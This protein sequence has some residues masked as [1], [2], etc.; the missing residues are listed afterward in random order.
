MRIR[1][2]RKLPEV[3]P[4]V[5]PGGI[6]GVAPVSV[7][8][9]GLQRRLQQLA[10]GREGVPLRMELTPEAQRLLQRRVGVDAVQS[11][12]LVEALRGAAEQGAAEEA[13]QAARE[14]GFARRLLDGVQSY[15]QRLWGQRPRSLGA[16]AAVPNSPEAGGLGQRLDP[17]GLPEY[18]LRNA[19]ANNLV[20][21]QELRAQ[22]PVVVPREAV[23][24]AFSAVG[25]AV[26][27]GGGGGFV[28]GLLELSG[29]RILKGRL[30]DLQEGVYKT[31]RIFTYLWEKKG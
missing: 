2:R 19:V 10:E 27:G 25:P 4:E 30:D 23:A 18:W 1:R 5:G 28:A 11:D 22:G 14:A 24:P 15:W 9:G 31:G 13:A 8:E 16:G 7:A 20:G 12:P 29:L 26:A 3:A 17:P 21:I 6:M